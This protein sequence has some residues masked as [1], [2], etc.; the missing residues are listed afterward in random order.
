SATFSDAGT[1]DG[2]SFTWTFGDG[3][4]MATGSVAAGGTT[5]AATHT[6]RR[7]GTYT[8]SVIVADG[9][10]A[11]AT[12]SVLVTV[13]NR[14]PTVAID[15]VGQVDEGATLALAGSVTA[16]GSGDAHATSWTF[17][18]GA[19]AATG[20]LPAGATR[21]AASHAWTRFGTYTVGLAATDGGGLSS[22]AQA[23][24]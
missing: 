23:T 8:A 11:T 2:H 24:V 7:F 9:A 12:A 14:P 18:D 1:A 21:T 22:S 17:G 13:A 15:P 20:T 16:P 3:A 4:A 19:P 10:A 5:A 6:Y